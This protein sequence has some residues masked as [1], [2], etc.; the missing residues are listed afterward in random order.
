MIR[1]YSKIL[2][3]IIWLVSN[4]CFFFFGLR[5][6]INANRTFGP[7]NLPMFPYIFWLANSLAS[8]LPVSRLIFFFPTIKNFLKNSNSIWKLLRVTLQYFL[9]DWCVNDYIS[10]TSLLWIS[11]AIWHW[12]KQSDF[13]SKQLV[14]SLKSWWYYHNPW[15]STINEEVI[16]YD[17]SQFYLFFFPLLPAGFP[18]SVTVLSWD[19]ILQSIEQ[20]RQ[21]RVRLSLT[22]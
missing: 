7:P 9:L 2:F 13:H 14:F 5:N 22:C 11:W 17:C 3:R 18:L 16:H 12:E 10:S 1:H 8:K 21:I 20:K 15:F 6:T 19:L 4:V